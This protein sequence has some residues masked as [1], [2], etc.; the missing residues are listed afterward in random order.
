MEAYKKLIYC[1]VDIINSIPL[2]LVNGQDE[3]SLGLMYKAIKDNVTFP[4][5]R[6]ADM[7][8]IEKT[9]VDLSMWFKSKRPLI[10]WPFVKNEFITWMDKVQRMKEAS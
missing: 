7:L 6:S 1:P 4:F 2:Y 3:Y 5:D 9:E 10:T 8:I